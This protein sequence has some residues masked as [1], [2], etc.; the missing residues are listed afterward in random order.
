MLLRDRRVTIRTYLPADYEWSRA[1]Y[2]VIYMF[3][4]HNLFDRCTSTY[5]KEWRVDE[6]MEQLHRQ[7]Q[8][9]PA[10]VVGIDAPPNKYDRMAMYSL[11]QWDYRRAPG[12]RRLKRI[13]GYGERTAAFLMDTVKPYIENTYRVSGDRE[14]VA[15]AGASMGGYMSLVVGTKYSESVSKVMAFSPVAMDFPMRGF[16]LRELIAAAGSAL[17]QRFYL[18]MGDR[19]RLDF[20]K[21]PEELVNHLARLR[22]T[23]EAA[24]HSDVLTRVVPGGRHDERAWA[25]RF[26]QAYLWSFFGVEP[27]SPTGGPDRS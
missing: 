9:P 14:Q 21:H 13:E 6:T 12:G 23:L 11:G 24:G 1:E 27:V 19:E 3:D 20:T 16:Q 8:W 4:A 2:R 7:G 26:P 25:R 17:P 5:N 18:D 10:V 22:E 15:A